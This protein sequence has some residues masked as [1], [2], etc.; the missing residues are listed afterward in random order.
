MD[1]KL[2]A[3]PSADVQGYSR[4]MREGKQT[5]IRMLIVCHWAMTRE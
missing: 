5:V 3:I 2:A 4:L 1:R